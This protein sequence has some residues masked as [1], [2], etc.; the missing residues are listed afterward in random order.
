VEGRLEPKVVYPHPNA[1]IQSRDSNFILGSVGNGRATLAINGQPVE[2]E[3]NGA[4]LAFVP[5]PAPTATPAY[6]LVAALGP[7]TARLTYPV[8]VAG[9]PVDSTMPLPPPLPPNVVTDTTPAWVILG[10][11]ASVAS[12]TDRVIIG[13]PGPNSVYRWFLFPG[14]RVQLTA[15]Y[16]GFARVRLDSALQIWVDAVDART[17]SA[18]TAPRH[19]QLAR[20]GRS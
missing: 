8:R 4:F 20:A 13:R 18:D 9:M 16:P 11:S 3:P 7:D 6:A 19:R 17:F 12:D 14:T 1:M 5:N 10:D 15:R 2:V